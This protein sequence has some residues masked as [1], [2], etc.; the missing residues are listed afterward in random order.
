MGAN[1]D[2][3]VEDSATDITTTRVKMVL[4]CLPYSPSSVTV[5]LLGTP[6]KRLLK[7]LFYAPELSERGI[8]VLAEFTR[9]ETGQIIIYYIRGECLELAATSANRR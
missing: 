4:T 1:T 2:K 9:Y 8:R 5:P 3:A 7:H 6:C